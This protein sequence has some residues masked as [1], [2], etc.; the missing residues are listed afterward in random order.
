MAVGRVG[1]NNF[2]PT[3]FIIDN[4]GIQDGATH[5]TIQ[6]AIDDSS[7]GDELYIRYGT[8]TYTEDPVLIDGITLGSIGDRAATL[9]EIVGKVSISSGTANLRGIKVTGD[10]DYAISCTDTGAINCYGCDLNA[11]DNDM[12]GNTGSGLQRFERCSLNLTGDFKLFDSSGSGG[13][14]FRRCTGSNTA[15][16]TAATHSGSGTLRVEYCDFPFSFSVSATSGSIFSNS[17]FNG[18]TRNITILTTAGTA[19]NTINNCFLESGTSSCISAGSGTTIQI[20]NTNLVSSNTNVVTGAGTVEY[21]NISFFG[22]SS[23]MNTTTLTPQNECHGPISFD[24]GSNF[25]DFYEKGS[26][27]PAIDG[28]TGSPTVTY[29]TQLGK[30]TR[31]GDVVFCKFFIAINTFSGGTGGAIITGLPFTS[32]N[33][34]VEERQGYVTQGMAWQSGYSGPILSIASNG[35]TI[36]LVEQGDNVNVTATPIGSIAAGDD[37]WGVFTFWA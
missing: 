6:S 23:L 4:N 34:S 29:T 27:T 2:S 22:S 16:T 20:A 9:P 21:G 26:W 28:T 5:A 24:E 7:A 11:S 3:K 19:N 8:G 35:T 33:D 12:I 17:T 1:T 14:F 30:Y 25:L 36:T 10:A 37:F 32:A 13:I 31:I 15:S 18:G